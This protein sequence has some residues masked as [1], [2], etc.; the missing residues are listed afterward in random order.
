MYRLYDFA[1]S[2]NCYKVRLLLTQL[3]IPFERINV[4]ILQ[5]ET[6]LPEFLQKNLNGKVPMLELAPDTFLTESNAILMY[7]AAETSYLPTNRSKQNQVMQWLFF[8]QS[9]LG[10]NLSRPRFWITVAQQAE[11][12]EAL[13]AYHQRL[14]NAALAV[15][16]Q[17]LERQP[18]LVGDRYTIADIAVFAYTHVAN[19]GGYDLNRLPA[20]QAWIERIQAQ[21][22][23]IS[24]T[25]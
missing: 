22:R 9:S 24:I 18:F 11:K 1:R 12:F 20:I 3:A 10:A 13:I 25:A 19:E 5:Q 4:N 16:E 7:L 2:G 8:E 21:P 23:H 14:G 17:H 15:V 6:R